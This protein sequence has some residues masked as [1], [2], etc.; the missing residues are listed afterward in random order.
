MTRKVHSP[1]NGVC[2]IVLGQACNFACRYCI[3]G[4]K[5]L[6]GC[7]VPIDKRIYDFINSF[8]G[9]IT[10]YGGEPLMYFR[11]MQQVILNSSKNKHFATMT[12]GSLIKSAEVSFLNAYNV[13]VNVSWD[14]AGTLQSRY[15]DVIRENWDNIRLID[16]LWITSVINKFNYPI[17][18]LSI[19]SEL[20]VD[21]YRCHGYNLR[22]FL[23]PVIKTYENEVFDV[24]TEKLRFELT[25]IMT[26]PVNF[27][28]NFFRDY[29]L[30]EI[31]RK[32]TKK[33]FMQKCGV[34]LGSVAIGLDGTMYQ[35]K[36]SQLRICDISEAETYSDKVIALDKNL[37]ERCLECSIA[38]I[39]RGGCRINDYQEHFCHVQKAFYE[40]I[41]EYSN[42]F[43]GRR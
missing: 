5:H 11:E 32:Y 14:G 4:K 39:C 31:K 37:N 8:D 22:L 3:E 26:T 25:R 29:I 24:D 23:E 27:G 18:L 1:H 9:C 19:I 41:L 12:N 16:D 43:F 2:Y 21:Y 33:M 17:E 40:P 15:R 7:R 10:F 35:C 36:N 38:K 13:S 28:E 6:G 30:G 42:Q 20:N 34:G